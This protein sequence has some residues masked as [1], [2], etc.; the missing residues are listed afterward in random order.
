MRVLLLCLGLFI[1]D[2]AQ[3]GADDLLREGTAEERVTRDALEW[4]PP[5]AFTARDWTGTDGDAPLSLREHIGEVVVIAF[6]DETSAPC[7][8]AIARLAKLQAE[9]LERGL[10][11]IAI[12]KSD[13][14]AERL[15]AFLA[16]TPLGFPHAIDDKGASAR[17]WQVN[18]YPDYQ[19][20]DRAGRVRVCDLID[21]DLPRAAR[22][23][24][25]EPG[26]RAKPEEIAATLADTWREALY[27]V[28]VDGKPAGSLELSQR[29]VLR[30][31]LRL[32]EMRDI[33]TDGEETIRTLTSCAV[34]SSLTPVK[35][36]VTELHGN[37]ETRLARLEYAQGKL[38][39]QVGSRAILRNLSAPVVSD[40]SLL[41]FAALVP[42]KD[43]ARLTVQRIEF[44]HGDIQ[45]YREERLTF[46]GKCELVLREG[47]VRR[48]VKVVRQGE[49]RADRWTFWF[50]E[51]RRF[52]LQ[53]EGR[54]PRGKPFT[55]KLAF[56]EGEED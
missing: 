43:R 36:V 35:I 7:R 47:D 44:V 5:P 24:L 54:T 46:D 4:K 17:A 29:I 11:I 15:A 37:G 14:D 40:L 3:Q 51:A 52:L 48:A 18:A 39:G 20:I 27:D 55:Y 23:L 45:V 6:W 38:R 12:H 56:V 19:L 53:V 28:T 9:E 30:S 50:D 10:R 21:S 1:A 34:D 41:R 2:G 22:K 33:R 32:L 49:R 8:R 13:P 16:E 31:S 26:P 42:F 25:D